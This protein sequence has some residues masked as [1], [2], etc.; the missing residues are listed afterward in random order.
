MFLVIVSTIL[1][2]GLSAIPLAKILKLS[3]PNPQG[4]LIA[5]INK[6]SIEISKMLSDY[7]IRV[8]LVD[9]NWD[10]VT[11]ARQKGVE[12]CFGSIVA[13]KT[14]E[15]IDLDR[16]GRFIALTSNKGINSLS[17]I[18]Y[19]KEFDSANVYQINTTDKI[20]QQTVKGLRGHFFSSDNLLYSDI[21]RYKNNLTVKANKITSEFTFDDII[22]QRDPKLFHP[23]FIISG[24]GRLTI[25][26]EKYSKT[27]VEGEIL[28]SLIFG[29]IKN[30][31][32]GI[33]T[34][35]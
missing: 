11:N 10:K 13:E 8:L 26:S 33:N 14:L 12:T 16:I 24:D 17:S 5:G 35:D 20:N 27:P 23:L 22:Q 7:N 19:S 1:V 28:I 3:D 9:K 15:N 4:I 18:Y 32:G 6:L 21:E 34:N 25:Y 31:D 29:E 30:I 2:Y